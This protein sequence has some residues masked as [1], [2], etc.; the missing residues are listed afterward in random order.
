LLIALTIPAGQPH[1][2]VTGAWDV[3]IPGGRG[4]I[5]FD[6]DVARDRDALV[7]TMTAR[8]GEEREATIA[9][10]GRAVTIRFQLDEPGAPV[11]VVMTGTVSGDTMKGTADFGGRGTAGWTASRRKP[12][13]H[14]QFWRQ[15]QTLCDGAYEGKVL[16]APPADTTFAGKRL[17]MHVRECGA[18][19]IR[20]PFHVGEDRSRTWVITRTSMGLV[21]KH[22][23][24]HEDGTPDKVTQYGG[25]SWARPPSARR[26]EFPADKETIALIP[27]A[28]TNIWT[29]E[30]D[31]GKAFVYALRRE[32]T[33]RRFRIE[34]DTSRRVAAP[35]PPWGAH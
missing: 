31:P 22:D 4:T 33:D 10:E 29:L 13:P 21:L 24:R 12:R 16:E 35:P 14:E 11:G 3:A 18:R 32:G 6:L 30:I 19:E 28:R 17:V 7:A 15:L 8:T 34:F 27:E 2:D 9:V 26:L 1:A 25:P 20:I 5:R 23:H